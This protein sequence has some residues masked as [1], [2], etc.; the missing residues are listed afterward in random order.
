MHQLGCVPAIP[1]IISAL[2]AGSSEA[3]R[4]ASASVTGLAAA[5][6]T[7][8]RRPIPVH[9]L[10]DAGGHDWSDTP[11]VER[12]PPARGPRRGSARR[13]GRTSRAIA[14]SSSRTASR[15]FTSA[16]PSGEIVV[17]HPAS[18]LVTALEPVMRACSGVWVAHGSGSADRES[19]DSRG[20]LEVATGDARICCAASG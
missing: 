17:Q 5:V 18:G 2:A 1:R 3:G 20:R 7:F 11:P 12:G 9:L 16:R 10:R 15:A 6:A 4:I 13:C 8:G 14:S 19:S